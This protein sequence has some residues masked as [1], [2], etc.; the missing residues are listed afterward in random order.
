MLHLFL[1]AG[2]TVG[3]LKEDGISNVSVFQ[4][5]AGSMYRKAGV[6]QPM[7]QRLPLMLFLVLSIQSGFLCFLVA[8][9]FVRANSLFEMI[10]C[11][12]GTGTTK[13]LWYRS[14]CHIKP[15]PGFA[16]FM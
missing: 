11:P 9:L 7:E 3:C 13:A 10:I 4:L 16:R 6:A 2:G 15:N 1:Q 12:V 14:S 5:T 8:L